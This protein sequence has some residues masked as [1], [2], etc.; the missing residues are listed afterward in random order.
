[1]VPLGGVGS[2][3]KVR[4]V[5]RQTCFIAG[6]FD[7]GD[8]FRD[9]CREP[10]LTGEEQPPLWKPEVA[11]TRLLPQWNMGA[12]ICVV[13]LGVAADDSPYLLWRC[14]EALAVGSASVQSDAARAQEPDGHRSHGA[15]HSIAVP[16]PLRRGS[17]HRCHRSGGRCRTEPEPPRQADSH[18]DVYGP[19]VCPGHLDGRHLLHS[20]HRA[21]IA[22]TARVWIG[23]GEN[24]P[25]A[26]GVAVPDR[27]VGLTKGACQHVP[28]GEVVPP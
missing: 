6:G 18:A 17:A 22:G 9:R 21:E 2:C 25:A 4:K 20:S 27:P 12:Q 24:G 19:V 26:R 14:F 1:M 13:Q 7:V 23:R 28:K 16:G 3:E 5:G 8:R 11:E 15:E 10:G